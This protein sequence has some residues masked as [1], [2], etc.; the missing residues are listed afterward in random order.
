M[1]NVYLIGMMGSG[2]TI[3][4]RALAKILSVPFVDL[5]D[6]IVQ[7]AGHSINEIFKNEGEPY[8]R[9]LE[10]DA[11]TKVSGLKNQVVATGG[12]IVMDPKN[13][14]QLKKTGLVI[15]LKTDLETLWQRVKRKTDRP[16]LAT[17]NPKQTFIELFQKRAPLYME[18]AERVVVTDQKSSEAVAE[19]IN[20]MCF[21]EKN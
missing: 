19:E 20:Q 8:F 17:A 1:K 3:T 15:Y 5:D 14:E 13:R 16:L 10:T 7:T 11:L 18:A 6:Q 4:G 12:G 21:H 9:H 2:K